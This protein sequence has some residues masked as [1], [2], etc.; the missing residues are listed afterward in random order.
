MKWM[1][2]TNAEQTP[3]LGRAEPSERPE[4]PQPRREEAHPPSPRSPVTPGS[5]EESGEAEA[6]A[7]EIDE[8]GNESFPAS[9]PAPGPL[10]IGR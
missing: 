10:H 9:D 7:D 5:R 1:E 2:P 3:L 8:L 6:P 4:P